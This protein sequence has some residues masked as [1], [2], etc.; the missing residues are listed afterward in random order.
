MRTDNQVVVPADFGTHARAKRL[1]HEALT[2]AAHCPT[3]D[4]PLDL[5]FSDPEEAAKRLAGKPSVSLMPNEVRE[6]RRLG[7]QGFAKRFARSGGPAAMHALVK[8]LER[9][10]MAEVLP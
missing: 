3:A 2:Y 4:W 1:V 9:L 8:C 5:V 10:D 6:L 7:K